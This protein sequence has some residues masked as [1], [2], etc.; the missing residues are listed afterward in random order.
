MFP[1]LTAPVAQAI[2]RMA[3]AVLPMAPEAPPLVALEDVVMDPAAFMGQTVRVHVQMHSEEPAWSP[4]LTR[5]TPAAYRAFRVWTDDQLLWTKQD[6]ET[7]KA[8]LFAPRGVLRRFSHAKLQERFLCTITVE[9]LFAGQA[10]IEVKRAIPT[11]AY[12]PEGVVLHAIKARELVERGAYDLAVGEYERALAAPLPTHVAD[13]LVRAREACAVRAG[14][15][16][17]RPMEARVERKRTSGV[18]R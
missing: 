14:K 8:R 16:K 11:R 4:Y 1:F 7:P 5:F 3:L 12:V 9:E 6:Y 18:R 17:G 10:W 13:C 2:L 15:H